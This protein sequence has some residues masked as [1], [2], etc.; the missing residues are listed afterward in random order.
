[1]STAHHLI[2][3]QSRQI[4]L[5]ES[6]RGSNPKS[7]GLVVDKKGTDL[8]IDDRQ[9]VS[10]RIP[11]TADGSATAPLALLGLA[12]GGT[13]R[14]EKVCRL[15]RRNHCGGRMGTDPNIAPMGTMDQQ[16]VMI[17]AQEKINLSPFSL[18]D[19]SLLESPYLRIGGRRF[20]DKLRIR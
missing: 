11:L 8:F 10:S 3:E 6:W 15:D 9:A 7:K 17:A 1:M 20:M 2:L 14:A 16:P 13:K 12:D 5:V 4:Q 18:Y 19:N